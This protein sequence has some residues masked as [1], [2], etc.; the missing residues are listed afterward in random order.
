LSGQFL[1]ENANYF[2]KIFF[3]AVGAAKTIPTRY[4]MAKAQLAPEDLPADLLHAE[5]VLVHHNGH[6][7]PLDPLYDSPFG[8]LTRSCDFFMLQIGGR[9]DTVSTISRKPCLDLAAAPVASPWPSEGGH[10]QL[11]TCGASAHLAVPPAPTATLVAPR[12]A[13]TTAGPPTPPELG[14]K[15]IFPHMGLVDGKNY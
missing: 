2:C 4:N 11:A 5:A 7:P 15:T 12:D 10:L 9:T 1:D 3:Q 6:M 14:A 8:V 13:L